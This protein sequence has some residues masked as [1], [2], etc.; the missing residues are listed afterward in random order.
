[1]AT[2]G[3]EIRAAFPNAVA[4]PYDMRA[5]APSLKTMAA[6]D[7]VARLPLFMIA[8]ADEPMEAD[9]IPAIIIGQLPKRAA[10]LGPL[11]APQRR[12][13]ARFVAAMAG[14]HEL[15][16]GGLLEALKVLG[17]PPG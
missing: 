4:A 9:P 12:V 8:A 2:L 11:T 7:F 3:E 10:E 15:A 1:M 16:K 5:L 6:D 13:V 14:D 17:A